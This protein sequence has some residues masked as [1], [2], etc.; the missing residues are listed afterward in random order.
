MDKDKN[1]GRASEDD[2]DAYESVGSGEDADNEGAS[3]VC[4][5]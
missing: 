1:D 3:K 2:E 5:L 4:I